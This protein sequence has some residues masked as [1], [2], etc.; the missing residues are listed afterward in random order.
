MPAVGWWRGGHP[1]G[2]SATRQAPT[3]ALLLNRNA[4]A[5]TNR[6]LLEVHAGWV[7]VKP[8]GR[9]IA[10]VAS[11]MGHGA[12]VYA[13]PPLA[14]PNY[15]VPPVRSTQ[16]HRQDDPP[17]LVWRDIFQQAINCNRTRRARHSTQPLAAAPRRPSQV[18]PPSPP[19]PRPARPSA[20]PPAAGSQNR[21]AA[22][23]PGI[24]WCHI[25][26]L[27][28]VTYKARPPAC[29][30][31]WYCSARCCLTF[32]TSIAID[33]KCRSC[34]KPR[35]LSEVSIQSGRLLGGCRGRFHWPASKPACV[36][37]ISNRGGPAT[38]ASCS[39]SERFRSCTQATDATT[40]AARSGFDPRI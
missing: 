33:S 16:W 20:S 3:S 37:S 9:R 35:R 17:L 13:H 29:N 31:L 8:R 14:A 25:I 40:V 7:I 1:S 10:R 30:V 12:G 11:C 4:L 26:R 24:N 18:P 5:S 28:A 15:A 39:R 6:R 34:R 27:A 36:M 2:W 19:R 21:R 23:S 22:W 38:L 32:E